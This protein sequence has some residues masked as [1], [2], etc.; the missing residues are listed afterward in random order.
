MHKEPVKLKPN[1]VMHIE[2][3][4]MIYLD[5]SNAGRERGR[6]VQEI[7]LSESTILVKE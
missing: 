7:K 4:M 3:T 2:R 1:L 5:K 6:I